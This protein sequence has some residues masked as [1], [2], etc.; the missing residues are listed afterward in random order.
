[1][2]A[3]RV[4]SSIV[5]PAKVLAGSLFPITAIPVGLTWIP[6]FLPSLTLMRYGLNGDSSGFSRPGLASVRWLRVRND[7]H[8]NH[9]PP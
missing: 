7:P 6:R 3:C 2:S 5:H 1:M 8:H 4:Y 9:T